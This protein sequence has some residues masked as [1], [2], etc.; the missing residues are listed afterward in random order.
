VLLLAAGAGLAGYGVWGVVTAARADLPG[1][2]GFAV[3][4]VVGH[5]LLLAPVTLAIGALLARRAGY[6]LR[7]PLLAGLFASLVVAL[8]ALPF[9]LGYGKHPDD[10]S[11]LPLDYSRGLLI[12]LGGI[13]TGTLAAGLARWTSRH[14]R[15]GGR[16]IRPGESR[17]P[18]SPG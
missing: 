18:D 1:Y 12:T 13:W 8:V 16:H 17:E 6:G 10:P 11:A 3:A 2:A 5:D 7:G 9:V 4:G 15:S 14:H